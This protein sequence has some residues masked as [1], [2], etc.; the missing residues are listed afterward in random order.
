MRE[1]GLDEVLAGLPAGLPLPVGCWLVAR[2]AISLGTQPRLLAPASIRIDEDG[3]VRLDEGPQKVPFHLRSPE[4]IRGGDTDDASAV[5]NLGGLL[6]HTLTGRPPFLRGSDMESRIAVSE[7]AVA[8]LVGRVAQ[9]SPALDEV[10]IKALRKD[11]GM[12][13]ET[14]IQFGEALHGYL[15]AELH[16]AEAADLGEIVK[17]LAAQEPDEPKSGSKA[18]GAIGTTKKAVRRENPLRG[19]QEV[20]TGRRDE[21]AGSVRPEAPR[22]ADAPPSTN[23]PAKAPKTNK[24]PEARGELR[25]DRRIG[26]LRKPISAPPERMAPLAEE[27]TEG[28]PMPRSLAPPSPES[29]PAP[30]P[31]PLPAPVPFGE[32]PPSLETPLG[33]FA[34]ELELPMAEESLELDEL[35]M[36]PAETETKKA[37]AGSLLEIDETALREESSYVPPPKQRAVHRP[38]RPRDEEEDDYVDDDVGT[39]WVKPVGLAL[40]G[41]LALAIVYQF[42]IRPLLASL[43]EGS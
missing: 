13:F 27:G 42:V 16:E 40:F 37:A 24:A 22:Q 23:K 43:S 33:E 6:V 29:A 18:I 10:V 28:L 39:A 11:P 32:M 26:G 15:E 9:A 25:A 30:E 36:P 7:E 8:K 34:D 1:V 21:R 20:D 17:S 12:R 35:T 4:A 3:T 19:I 31:E 38:P 5:F 14:P 2:V 41:L